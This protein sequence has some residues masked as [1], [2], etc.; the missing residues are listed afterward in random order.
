MKLLILLVYLKSLSG[1]SH[2]L[3][4]E[5]G[6]NVRI[7]IIFVILNFTRCNLHSGFIIVLYK[8]AREAERL[9]AT[10]AVAAKAV[11]SDA[12]ADYLKN[13]QNAAEERKKRNRLQK[14]RDEC[15]RLE[16]ALAAIEEE[17]AGDAATDYVRISEL[18]A[19]KT[20]LEEQLLADYEELEELEA[21]A[22]AHD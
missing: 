12:K 3:Y 8:T 10:A 13:K 18:D 2:I 20:E 17:M 14:L 22:A 1:V 19:K 16:E 7:G 6:G 9:G 5:N 21:W 15:V 11:V 4:S